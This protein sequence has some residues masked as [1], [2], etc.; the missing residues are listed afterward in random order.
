MDAAEGN[1]I[2]PVAATMRNCCLDAGGNAQPTTEMQYKSFGKVQMDAETNQWTRQKNTSQEK[3]SKGLRE[4]LFDT[5]EHECDQDNACV[6]GM[7]KAEIACIIQCRILQFWDRNARGSV[8][9][10]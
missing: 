6:R 10:R 3:M 9:S 4:Q 2:R 8:L 1:G 7:K 5:E